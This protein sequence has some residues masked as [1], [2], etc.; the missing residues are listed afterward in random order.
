MA[1]TLP[2]ILPMLASLV[3]SATLLGATASPAFANRGAPDYRLT[4]EQT[5]TG[6]KVARDTLWRCADNGCTAAAANSRP[7]VVCA[8][9][10]REV[11]KVSTFSFRGAAFDA[12]ALAKCNTKAR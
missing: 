4:V 8:Q 12:D 5:V 11:G 10:V 2:R 6:N 9:I 1:H 7:E 3:V